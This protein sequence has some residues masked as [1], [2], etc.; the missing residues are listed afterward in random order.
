MI[1]FLLAIYSRTRQVAAK[2]WNFFVEDFWGPR[3]AKIAVEFCTE[4]A[5]LVAIF[6]LLDTIIKGGHVTRPL[7]GW[8]VGL[9]AILLLFAGVI[10]AIIKVDGED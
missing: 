1:S 4:A 6:P 3:L 9:P 8:S 5:V 7:I 2:L 10:A